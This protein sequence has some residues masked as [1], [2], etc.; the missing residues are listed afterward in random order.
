MVRGTVPPRT[1]RRSHIGVLLGQ[2]V[3]RLR[4]PA[5]SLSR[6][7][8]QQLGPGDTRI[9]DPRCLSPPTSRS[10]TRERARHGR[11]AAHRQCGGQ[12][13]PVFAS[14]TRV[15]GRRRRLGGPNPG[16]A[17][18]DA[19]DWPASA[20]RRSSRSAWAAQQHLT[21]GR[22]ART[23]WRVSLSGD[24]PDP[25]ACACSRYRRPPHRDRAQLEPAA[26]RHAGQC[27]RGMGGLRT[28]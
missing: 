4:S 6:C 12:P 13:T 17:R 2:R 22:V 9:T 25:A 27:S 11:P 5:V 15:A 16:A 21:I 20:R 3:R 18:R 28:E 7:D 26:Q 8:V 19:I 14:H 24:I 10:R 1:T 23:G